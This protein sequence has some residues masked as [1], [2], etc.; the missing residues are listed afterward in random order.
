MGD[1]VL[2]IG[3][4]GREHALA[5]K[6]AHSDHVSR[7]FVAPGNAGTQSIAKVT[8]VSSTEVNCS[9]NEDVVKFCKENQID[10]VVVGPEAPLA[11]GIA[12]ELHKAEI[13][14]FGPVKMAARIESS[15][16]FAKEFMKRHG[17][18]TAR[19]E[20]FTDFEKAI[21]HIKNADYPALVVKAS[22][23]AAGKGV[24]VAKDR[25]EAEEAVQDMLKVHI[26][27]ERELH[28]GGLQFCILRGGGWVV[29]KV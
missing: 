2:L 22:G 28:F 23:L 27:T 10:F 16:A 8:N 15:K 19:F 13:M 5:W 17:I 1:R 18:P 3:G 14:C 11:N 9:L 25:S 29:C 26:L 6:L 24:I 4:G 7:I 12:D 20:N 21:E